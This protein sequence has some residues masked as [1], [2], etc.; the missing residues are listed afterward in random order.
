VSAA[1]VTLA[2]VPFVT[3][4][5]DAFRLAQR[6]C[7]QA[8]ATGSTALLYGAPGNGKTHAIEQF[9]ASTDRPTVLITSSPSP[10]RKEIFEELLIELTGT[11]DDMS[12]TKLRRA[13]IEVLNEVRPVVAVDE[14]QQLSVL[15]LQ[16]VRSLHDQGRRTWPL[17]LIGTTGCVRRLKDHAALWSR[18]SYRVEFAP[19]P[20][21]RIVAALQRS[22]PLLANTPVDLLTKID[23]RHGRGNWRAWIE[24]CRV[25]FPLVEA[26]PH[27]DRLTL[28]V[29]RAAL[30]LIWGK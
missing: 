5:T 19:L 25:A 14:A 2:E 13:C 15:W 1:E 16:Q 3:V 9:L 26:S 18:I 7:T 8:T 6:A 11:V 24:L 4:E 12:V 22:H 10:T 29:V 20:T 23:E 27:P 30:T 28:P 17:M 21:Q